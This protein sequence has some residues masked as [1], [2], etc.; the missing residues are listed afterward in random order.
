MADIVLDTNILAEFLDQYFNNTERGKKPFHVQQKFTKRLTTTI[1][2]ITCRYF[3]NYD[4]SS[5]IIIASSFAFIE[6]GR[7]WVEISEGK[8]TI[9]QLAA[10]IE[11]PPEWFSIAPVDED[12]LEFF[13][14]LPSEI[15][16]ADNIAKPIEWTD[17][18]HAATTLSRGDECLL[19]TTDQ[20]LKKIDIL[21]NRLII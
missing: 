19:A 5:G 9:F 4:L 8:F 17:A 21:K 3:Q 20:R 14:Y 12:L 16:L 6:I 1:N 13:F 11:Q 7:K 2:K 10:F 15:Y 18:V